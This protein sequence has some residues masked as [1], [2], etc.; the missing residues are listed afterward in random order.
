LRKS[1]VGEQFFRI[2]VD[3]KTTGFLAIE[4]SEF[5]WDKRPGVRIAERGWTFEA[6]GRARSLDHVVFL[7]NDL[8]NERWKTNAST[9]VPGAAALPG[10]LEVSLEEG[11]RTKDVLLSSQA[12]AIGQPTVENPALKLPSSYISRG[13]M[14]LLPQLVKD[15]ERPR[16]MAFTTF[17]HLRTDL[18][19]RV[20]EIK[21]QGEPPGDAGRGKVFR[22]DEREGLAS[23]PSSLY[24]DEVGRILST[25]QGRVTMLHSTR[26]EMERELG[27]RVDDA[28][29]KMSLLESTYSKDEERFRRAN[30]P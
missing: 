21:G 9:L 22:I 23:E 1:L 26:Q 8:V 18:V 27:A 7:S 30:G 24:V 10:H 12:Y 28:N 15:L 5:V 11:L 20:V 6:D 3:G 17:D 13:L 2:T 25:R 29:R 16:R 14:R 19:V 4:Q